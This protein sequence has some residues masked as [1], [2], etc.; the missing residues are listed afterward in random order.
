MSSGKP[1]GVV[2]GHLPGGLGQGGP[3]G[4][5]R[6]SACRWG[7]FVQPPSPGHVPERRA[8]EALEARGSCGRGHA[9]KVPSPHPGHVKGCQPCLAGPRSAEASTGQALPVRPAWK[10]HQPRG[11]TPSGPPRGGRFTRS[12]GPA[13]RQLATQ[14]AGQ[15]AGATVFILSPWPPCCR[16]AFRPPPASPAQRHPRPRVSPP[17]CQGP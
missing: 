8:G 14:R 17:T 13:R 9:R 16:G 4:S 12:S 7:G 11:G 5:W 10:V 15:Q 2:W 6:S 3:G 1:A